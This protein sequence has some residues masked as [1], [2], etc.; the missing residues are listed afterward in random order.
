MTVHSENTVNSGE[1]RRGGSHTESDASD[2][3]FVY[4]W[5]KDGDDDAGRLSLG[6]RPVSGVRQN[7]FTSFRQLVAN[8]LSCR[9]SISRLRR[10]RTKRFRSRRSVSR[11]IIRFTGCESAS[12]DRRGAVAHGSDH[13]PVNHFSLRPSFCHAPGRPPASAAERAAHAQFIIVD[14]R[15]I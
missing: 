15:A 3:N 13:L 9:V 10:R 11:P 6:C 4:I 8:C 14:E 5:C 7:S 12:C 2:P 1:G